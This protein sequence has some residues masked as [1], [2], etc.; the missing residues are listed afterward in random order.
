MKVLTD[1]VERFNQLLPVVSED[2]WNELGWNWGKP[3]QHLIDSVHTTLI[4]IKCILT[5]HQ[6]EID[7]CSSTSVN[8]LSTS[9]RSQPGLEEIAS[10][11]CWLVNVKANPCPWLQSTCLYKHVCV[12]KLCNAWMDYD[13]SFIVFLL[14]FWSGARMSFIY[15]CI[16]SLSICILY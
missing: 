11:K 4:R 16:L 10:S 2:G 9:T 8:R 1:L 3:L 12:C 7:I 6:E 13:H 15:A 5:R 14:K